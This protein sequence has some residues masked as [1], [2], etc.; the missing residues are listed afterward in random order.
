M[1]EVTDHAIETW[2]AHGLD[3]MLA[4]GP[5]S[6]NGYVRMPRGLRKRFE[7]YDDLDTLVEVHC[8]VT[9]GGKDPD[10]WF[11]FDTNHAGDSWPDRILRK[12]GA[13]RGQAICREISDA[14]FGTAG[15]RKWTLKK[16][17]KEVGRFA[18][19]VAAIAEEKSD[20]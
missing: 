15:G 5:F 6:I 20:D 8:G 3:C 17:R 9:Y 13:R 11:G 16:L 12:Y 18:K 2:Q 19:Q 7:N 1:S 4:W 14:F 10:G